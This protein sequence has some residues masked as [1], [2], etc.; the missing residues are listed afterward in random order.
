MPSGTWLKNSIHDFCRLGA[1]RMNATI[2]P[3]KGD[4]SCVQIFGAATIDAALA[5]YYENCP[6][7]TKTGY[8]APTLCP[9]GHEYYDGVCY[10]ISDVKR[11]FVEAETDC[12]S[13][14]DKKGMYDSRLMWTT[15]RHHYA[16]IQRRVNKKL[17][18]DQFWIGL[19]DRSE[20]NT[21]E[22]RSVKGS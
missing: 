19:D 18:E 20:K 11:P 15:K 8:R 6:D 3:F 4:V 10:R 2:E 5:K 14:T 7:A 13:A 22:T 16:Y 17:N 1:N 9:T 12:M 21:W